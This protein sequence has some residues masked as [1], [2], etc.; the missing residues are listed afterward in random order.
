LRE[1]ITPQYEAKQNVMLV[2]KQRITCTS[3]PDHRYTHKNDFS[4]L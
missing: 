1:S 2:I 3:R 4:C